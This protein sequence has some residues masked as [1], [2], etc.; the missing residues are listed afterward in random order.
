MSSGIA[1]AWYS[2]QSFSFDVN[3]SDN[4]QHYI[5]LYALDWDMQGRSESIQILDAA[6]NI[7]LDQ[8]NISNFAN[9][10]F[11]WSGEFPAT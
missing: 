6:S 9:A 5:A 11:T 4:Q 2:G 3:L 1:T 10:A 7:Q 8:K